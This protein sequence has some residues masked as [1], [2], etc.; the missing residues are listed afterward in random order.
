M[1]CII[2]YPIG[3]LYLWIRYRHKEKV[4]DALHKK[5]DG[6][7]YNA[8]VLLMTSF[9]GIVLIT[10][11]SLFLLAVIGRSIYDAIN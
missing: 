4:K 11:L 10:L 6:S 2:V 3:W 7:Y 5:Y 1:M 8:G 9:F